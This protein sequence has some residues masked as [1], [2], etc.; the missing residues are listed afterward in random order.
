MKGFIEIQNTN[1]V[2]LLL[3]VANI[4]CV[5]QSD[6]GGSGAIIT[7]SSTKSINYSGRTSQ[8]GVN[9]KAVNESIRIVTN[10]EYNEVKSLIQNAL[11]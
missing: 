10:R 4:V 9:V 5:R 3:N 6:E 7:L 8:M 1:G 2:L 11:K